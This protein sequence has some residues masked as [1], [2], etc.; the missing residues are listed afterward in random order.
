MG[1]PIKK[2]TRPFFAVSNKPEKIF[3]EEDLEFDWHSGMSWQVRQRS[4]DS[5]ADVIMN[6]YGTKG[7]KR[8]EIL[9]VSTASRDEEVGRTLSALNLMFRDDESGQYHSVENWFQAAKVFE[10]C[11]E[12]FGPYHELL[13][14]K[15]P[16][17]YLNTSLSAD[18]A[19]QY[20]DDPLFQR[21]QSEIKGSKLTRFELS[22]K[23]YPLSPKSCFYDY[24]YVS[25]LNQEQ[26]KE[27]SEHI[28][29]YRV[30]TDIMFTPGSGKKQKYNTQARSCAIF[31]GLKKRGVMRTAL[32][33]IDTFIKSVGY[34]S[35]AQTPTQGELPL[36]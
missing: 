17:R 18:L 31:V 23:N 19:N 15:I 10:N 14:T 8:E 2:A 24:L 26:N 34:P 16:K 1:N 30:F 5:F 27:L 6:K 25:A 32:K 4:S 33:D 28:T 13:Q 11:G 12:E 29:Q 3:Y 20:Q 9:E 35:P 22:G 21:I 36:K 7:L